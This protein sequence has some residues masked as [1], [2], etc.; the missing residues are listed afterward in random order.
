MKTEGTAEPR[1]DSQAR[2]RAAAF[3]LLL[4]RSAPIGQEALA[5]DTG[6]GLD[7]V[8]ELLDQ[9][10]RA[11]R[12][13]RDGAGKVVASAGLSIVPDRH[14]VEIEG[15]RFWTWCAYDIV[16]IFGALAA[17]G[18]ALSRSPSGPTIEVRFVRGRPEPTDAVLFRP[19][20]DLRNRCQ[21]VYEEWCPNSNLFPN[22][23]LAERWAEERGLRG[24]VLGLGEA[25]SLATKEWLS[26]A[27]GASEGK[28]SDVLVAEGD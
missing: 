19:H 20:E 22:A 4:A 7:R 11:G 12:I 18:H 25:G 15:R 26:L 27:E 3:R 24:R 28:P 5:R 13:R 1:I 14:E 2:V 21:N 23:Q 6:M 17:S 9:L 10:D 8:I 16:G